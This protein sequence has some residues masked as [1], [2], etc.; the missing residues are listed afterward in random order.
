LIGILMLV[1]G[2]CLAVFL[3]ATPIG[4]ILG[5]TGRVVLSRLL[6]LLLAALAVQTVGDGVLSFGVKLHA[7]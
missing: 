7:G 5:N 2:S 4:R 1:M 6:G 3:L